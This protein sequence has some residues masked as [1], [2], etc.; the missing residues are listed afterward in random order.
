MLFLS[1]FAKHDGTPG[2]LC[3]SCHTTLVQTKHGDTKCEP[4]TDFGCYE[5][6]EIMWIRSGSHC[7]GFFR[8]NAGHEAVRCGSRYFRPGPGE[9]ERANCSCSK[10]DTTAPPLQLPRGA[11]RCGAH[12][13]VDTTGGVSSAYRKLPQ[14]TGADTSVK[15]CRNKPTFGGPIDYNVTLSFTTKAGAAPWPEHC[16]PLCSQHPS[17]RCRFFSHSMVWKNCMFCAACEPEIMIG[18]GSQSSYELATED[19]NVLYT[20]C[21]GMASCAEATAVRAKLHRAAL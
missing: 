8:C 13:D 15:C 9:E 11:G 21:N 16:E 20:G 19:P 3:P 4:N 14:P 1:S 18:D 17:G 6:E 12:A 7:G 2:H 5:G 10:A